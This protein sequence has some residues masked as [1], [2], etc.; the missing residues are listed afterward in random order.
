[1]KFELINFSEIDPAAI[2]NYCAIHNVSEDLNL[3]DVSK[4]DSNK[5]KDFNIM[6]WGFP[7]VNISKAGNL[8]GFHETFWESITSQI[9]FLFW[10]I[11]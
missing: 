9:S 6:T 3:G 7:C 1:M 8:K 5:I 2:K 4:I 10:I 11:R